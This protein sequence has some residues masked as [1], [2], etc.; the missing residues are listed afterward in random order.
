M[1][2]GVKLSPMSSVLKPQMM[3]GASS[4]PC[5]NALSI[6]SHRFARSSTFNGRFT[7]GFALLILIIDIIIKV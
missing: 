4:D 6:P 5:A 3:R 2:P 1:I 7:P